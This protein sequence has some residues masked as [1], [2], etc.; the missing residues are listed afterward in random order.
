MVDTREKIVTLSELA[1][2]AKTIRSENKVLVHCHGEFGRLHPGH[3]R[4]LESA[5]RRGDVL[6]VTLAAD[7]YR[8]EKPVHPFFNERLRAESL[9][10]LQ[11]VDYVAVS[12]FPTVAEVIRILRPAVYVTANEPGSDRNTTDRSLL[13]EKQAVEEVGGCIEYAEN[14]LSTSGHLPDMRS[15]VLTEEARS[16]L[17]EFSRR[18][19]VHEII[20]RLKRLS[21]LKVLVV[22]D[23]IID[24]YC[25]CRAVGKASKSANVTAQF[26]HEESYAGGAVAVANNVAGFC[27]KVE[28]ATCLGY[29]DSHEEFVRDHLKSNVEPKFFFRPDAPTVVK[30]RFVDPFMVNKMFEIFYMNDEDLPRPIEQQVCDHL[31]EVTR[32]YDLVI[33]SDFGHGFISPRIIETLCDSSRFLAVNAQTNSQNTG[34]NLATKYS[35]ADYLCIDENEA[36]LA[37]HSK[38]GPLDEIIAGLSERLN[39]NTLSVTQGGR[40]SKVYSA[41]GG[42]AQAPAFATEVVDTVGAGDAYLSVT[43]LCAA[44]GEPCELIGL[45]GNAVG[46]LAV[47]I[48]GNRESIERES[49]FGF[50]RELFEVTEQDHTKAIIR[51]AAA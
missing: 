44:A 12:C 19:S 11:A 17:E 23:T 35:R 25:F 27:K 15:P 2:I 31:A 13:E 40:G 46:A 34:F 50:I 20:R 33:A 21:D 41:G 5:R 28:L 3:L 22:G 9:A 18:Y 38:Y 1:K 43:S 39:C 29:E 6:V 4:H 24:D 36:R 45:L 26:L 32:E 16:F 30:R 47:R 37:A 42:F 7:D 14:I 48:V 8:D 51:A 10:A 49:L